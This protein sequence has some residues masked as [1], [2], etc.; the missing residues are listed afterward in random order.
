MGIRNSLPTTKT[1]AKSP[2]TSKL[3]I[4]INVSPVEFLE[5]R[6]IEHIQDTIKLNNIK[7]E[8]LKIE[9]TESM[10]TDISDEI[11]QKMIP[12]NNLGVQFSLDGFG[13]SHSSMQH[14]SKLP[15]NELKIDQSIISALE[16]DPLN[17]RL[18]RAITIMAKELKI[19]VIAKGVEK[20]KQQ[21]MLIKFGC[22]NYQGFLYSKPLSIDKFEALLDTKDT[23]N[24]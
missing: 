8:R 18:V 19:N 21:Q 10:L 23:L 15:L 17:S 9:L 1:L 7:H 12:L 22:F 14:L 13:K 11:I 20:K 16:D 4:T 3:T 24:T 6:F 2:S 5:E